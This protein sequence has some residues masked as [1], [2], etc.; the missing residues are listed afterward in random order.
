MTLVSNHLAAISNEKNGQFQMKKRAISDEKAGSGKA[1][2]KGTSPQEFFIFRL[3]CLWVV[4]FLKSS[5]FF[6]KWTDELEA[7]LDVMF[8]G[9]FTTRCS[10]EPPSTAKE[11]S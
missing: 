5:D 6:M 1:C 8:P 7:V 4:A 3:F 11:T 9:T 2:R 10:L